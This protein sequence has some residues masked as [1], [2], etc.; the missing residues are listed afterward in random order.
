MIKKKQIERA[1]KLVTK[2][3]INYQPYIFAEDLQTGV[4]F[5]FVTGKEGAGLVYWPTIDHQLL[6]SPDMKRFI[7]SNDN[8]HEFEK[9]NEKLRIT[10]NH[11]IDEI[12]EHIG[13]VSKTTFADIGCNSGYFPVSFSL[14]G[15]NKSVGY[16]RENYT[17]SFELLN[18]ILGTNASFI[19]LGYELV[20]ASISSSEKYDVAISMMVLCHLSDALR[21][22]S[23]LG[24]IARKAIFIWTLITDDDDYRII[25]GEPNKYY[26]HDK[27]P[28][29]FD[30][31]IRPSVKLLYKSLEL[32]GFTQ[33]YEI[34]NHKDGIPDLFCNV[35]NRAVLAIRPTA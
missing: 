28:F 26:R 34:S 14:R 29:C 16:D 6:A 11:F 9:A 12:C 8:A 10:Y 3:L 22:L 25:Y 27:F 1:Q 20:N 13:N 21:H 19:P 32:M 15:A 31:L 30:N 35:K 7:I 4:G 24:S 18:E 17:E 5:E 33:I 23:F 2:G